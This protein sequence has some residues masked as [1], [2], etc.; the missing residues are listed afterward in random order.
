[1]EAAR[2]RMKPHVTREAQISPLSVLL[3]AQVVNIVT[4]Q[5]PLSR[6][7]LQPLGKKGGYEKGNNTSTNSESS[8]FLTF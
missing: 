5:K 4:N 6:K 3:T 7:N 8:D 2:G 1:M